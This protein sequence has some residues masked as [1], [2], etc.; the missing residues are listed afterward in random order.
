MVQKESDLPLIMLSAFLKDKHLQDC[1]IAEPIGKEKKQNK[2]NR[3]KRK[4]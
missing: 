3:E 1:E 4:N 2:K